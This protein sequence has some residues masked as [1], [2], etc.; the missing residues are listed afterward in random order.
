MGKE[1]SNINLQY[2]RQLEN[3]ENQ[4]SWQAL[5]NEVDAR[6]QQQIWLDQ[7]INQ[8]QQQEKMFGLESERWQNQFD[9]QNQYNAP[10]AQVARL[11][12]AGINPAALASQLSTGSSSASLG[13][14]TGAS[15]PSPSGSFGHNVTPGHLNNP[16]GV[17]SD[18]AIFSSIAQLNDSLSKLSQTGLNVERQKTLLGAELESLV[19]GTR[20]ERASAEQT[21]LQNLLTKRFGD[22]KVSA[23]INKMVADAYSASASGNLSKAKELTEAAINQATSD[24]NFR[25]NAAFPLVI[26]NLEKRL[27]QI[28]ADINLKGSQARQADSSASYMNALTSTENALRDGRITSLDLSN[29]MAEIQKMIM[30]RENIR[31][32]ATHEDKIH[33]IVFECERSGLINRQIEYQID[34]AIIDRDWATVEHFF[35]VLSS[36]ASSV[37]SVGNVLVGS[38]RNA[39]QREFNSVWSDYI[40]NKNQYPI[41]SGRGYRLD[42]NGLLFKRP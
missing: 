34:K 21:E 26:K 1:R 38:E 37:G 40:N 28:D 41:E 24:D 12:A 42:D 3:Q 22:S 16:V 10:E 17:S 31:D 30:N 39:V 29:K 5:Q 23:E 18:A 6:R 15:S 20:S 35:G 7:F 36:A 4:N 19:T 2:D 27:E 14:S 9:I 13:A 32:A 11:T 33:K 25:K 8:S